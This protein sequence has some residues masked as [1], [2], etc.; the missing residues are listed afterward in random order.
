MLVRSL[1]RTVHAIARQGLLV[2]CKSRCSENTFNFDT[3]AYETCMYVPW[4]SQMCASDEYTVTSTWS[5]LWVVHMQQVLT[6]YIH[7]C[8]YW[9]QIHDTSGMSIWQLCSPEYGAGWCH[10]SGIWQTCACIF[11]IPCTAIMSRKITLSQIGGWV[12]VVSYVAHS[13]IQCIKS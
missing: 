4:T 13:A 6:F 3:C 1:W 2:G 7:I 12:C 8:S 10:I 11:Y 5:L 9:Q